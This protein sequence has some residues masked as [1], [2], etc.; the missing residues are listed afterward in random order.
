MKLFGGI[1][2]GG[3]K[4]VCSVG[5]D[6]DHIISDISF[7]TTNPTETIQ[8]TIE[9]FAPY[10]MR[11]ELTSV[12][13]ASFGPVDLNPASQT[14]GFITT[15][16][17]TG[18]QQVDLYGEIQKAL[19]VPIAFDTD[20]NAAAFGEKYWIPEN[21]PLDPF[22]YITVGTGIGV[23]AIINGSPLH[24]LIHA[25]A[26][27]MAIPHNWEKDPFPG[28]CPFHGDCLEGLASGISMNKRWGQSPETL[29]D[30]HPAWDLEA[31]YI[32][33]ALVNLIYAYSPQ[34]IILGGGVSQHPGFHQAVRQKVL[35]INNGYV[36]SI[37]IS[38]KI[39]DYILPPALGN[40]S[41]VLGAIAMAI[42]LTKNVE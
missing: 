31:K 38:E 17:K 33:L 23:G 27:H 10:S 16:P 40:R 30:S 24:G 2:S 26:G 5:R 21:Q 19:K 37:F 12:G 7:P 3:T 11:N 9:F 18:W 1:E 42:N 39:D 34:R 20:V 22:L 14:F 15:T 35:K 25:E 6:P 41:G 13:I 8:K 29:S 4:F 32:A 28:V 36:N